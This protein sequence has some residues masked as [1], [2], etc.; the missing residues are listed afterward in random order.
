VKVLAHVHMYVP[1]HNAGAELML[2]TLLRHLVDQDHEVRVLIARTPSAMYAHEDITCSR[3]T[4]R[5]FDRWYQWADVAIT[6]LDLTR[7][8]MSYAQKHATPLVHIVHN[9]RQLT[10]HRVEHPVGAQLVVFN[11][12]WIADKVRWKGPSIVIRPPVAADDYRTARGSALTLV[13]LSPSKGAEIFYELAAR[14]PERRFLGVLGAYGRQLRPRVPL[15]N[16][17]IVQNTPE[18]RAVYAQTRI[19]LMPSDYESW[20]RV[21]IEAAASGIPTI[22]HPTPGL[23]ESLGD[24]GIFADRDNVDMWVAAIQRLDDETTYQRQAAV[25][26]QRSKELDPHAELE[27][28]ERSLQELIV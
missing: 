10:Y 9:D 13:N 2:H 22:A 1:H 15:P 3:S 5:E 27:M 19:L 26:Q 11:S 24:A 17:T 12:R 18:I 4:R 7:E 6:H 28:F 20:G 16:V 23:C 21:A 8:A 25:V 14:L